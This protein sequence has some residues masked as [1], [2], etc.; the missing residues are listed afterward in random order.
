MRRVAE[1]LGT[2]V[3]DEAW[4]GL[5]EAATFA[6]MRSRA[7]ETAPDVLGVL[8]DPAAFFR[9]GRSGAGREL[10][11]P[12]ELAAYDER[13]AALAPPDLVAWLHR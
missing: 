4:P 11:T 2:P 5:V 12:D 3:P 9:R 8:K 1:R 6:Q 10:L 13:V 7:A